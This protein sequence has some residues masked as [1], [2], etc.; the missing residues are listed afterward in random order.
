MSHDIVRDWLQRHTPVEPAL[1]DGRGFDGVVNE[2][3]RALRLEG[4]DAYVELLGRAPAEA[5]RLL[6]AIA[7]P[8]SWLF[9]YPE[10]FELLAVHLAALR[11]A[12]TSSTGTV[13]RTLR[14]LSVACAAGQEPC[15]IAITA[16]HAGWPSDRVRILA[17]D[18]DRDRLAE[19]RLGRYGGRPLRGTPPDW[20]R[21]WLSGSAD[22]VHVAPDVV[23]MIE[24]IHGDALV[25]EELD[26]FAPYD[27][28]FC[29]N[30][31][32]YLNENARGALADRLARW[33]SGD[34]LLFVG[35][36]ELLGVLKA[37]FTPVSEPHSFALRRRAA[38]APALASAVEDRSPGRTLAW[39]DA[40]N[41]MA[42]NPTN[43]R[44]TPARK[45]RT[46]DA[47][48]QRP[49][50]STPRISLD[51]ARTCADQ[52]RLEEALLAAEQVRAA[53]G[54][55]VATLELLGNIQLALGRLTDARDSFRK[56]V[57]LEPEHEGAL[58]QLALI[59]DRIGET[60]QAARYRRRAEHAH[61]ND[62]ER[63]EASDD[64]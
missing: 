46:A 25:T 60:V 33:V 19:A 30:L 9:R 18:V 38:D 10:S 31:L 48:Q 3:L 49:R 20:A 5:E 63:S 26:G 61:W 2:R 28:V 39:E 22:E 55:N 45:R 51:E 7:V 12:A 43:S 62:V 21:P 37:R 58:L 54:P 1:L 36:A 6:A 59:C 41:R 34:G 35:H 57:Y 52:G 53:E 15:S 8:E 47:P 24:F 40:A 23:G 11:D 27:A 44:A 64:G 17:I 14:M 32:I 42:M 16:L 50:A 13:T 56:V 29:R 4:D